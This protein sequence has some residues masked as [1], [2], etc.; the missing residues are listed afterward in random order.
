MEIRKIAL[1]TL[2]V[3]GGLTPG[4]SRV[5]DYVFI[6]ADEYKL[7]VEIVVPP[8]GT[9][10]EWVPLRAS[11]HSGPWKKIPYSQLPPETFWFELPPPASEREVADNLHWVSEPLGAA[12]FD[13]PQQTDP[14]SH[15]RHV[16]FSRPGTYRLWGDNAY[17]TRG[18]SNVATILIQVK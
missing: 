2:I 18:K 16:M 3:C 15:Q 4:C 8:R 17:P 7:T 12:R 1:N 14:G 5:P 11:R 6:P 13:L 9:V 10:D